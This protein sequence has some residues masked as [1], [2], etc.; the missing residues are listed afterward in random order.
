MNK[1]LKTKYGIF[2]ALFILFM[3]ERASKYFVINKLPS[4][5]VY[6]FKYLQLQLHINTGIAWGLNLPQFVIFTLIIIIILFLFYY[7]LKSIKK[8]N[9]VYTFLLGLVIVGALANL[10]DRIVYQGVVD[11]IQIG[12]WPNFNLADVF[13]GS[14]VLI[15]LFLNIKKSPRKT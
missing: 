11:F 1:I 13:I 3:I 12:I 10:L 8:N 15:L 5:G 14:G 6:F 4:Q 7:F 9:F 2:F